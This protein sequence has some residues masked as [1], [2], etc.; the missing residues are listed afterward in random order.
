MIKFAVK[1]TSSILKERKTVNLNNKNTN[2]Q[3]KGR[4]DPCVGISAV[5]VGE[6]MVAIILADL[7][8]LNQKNKI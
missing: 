1:P 8:L 5:P 2:I 6:A 3:T 4:H 7:F